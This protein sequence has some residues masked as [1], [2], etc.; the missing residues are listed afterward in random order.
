[1]HQDVRRAETGHRGE[2]L[3]VGQA[4]RHVVDHDGTGGHRGLGDDRAH[5]VD[6]DVHSLA[7][8]PLDDRDDPT[9]LLVDRRAQRSGPGGLAAHVD[10]VG[11]ARG[12]VDP[13]GDGAVVVEVAPAVGER[14]GRDVE[15]AHHQAAR[16]TG[17]A[18]DVPERLGVHPGSVSAPGNDGTD[19][20]TPRPLRAGASR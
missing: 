7:R 16:R 17:Q 12:Q 11:P 3:P 9:E 10:Q 18:V 20:R 19:G 5:R 8:Q 6:R 2:H 13:V 4:A 15:D 14:V 1:V